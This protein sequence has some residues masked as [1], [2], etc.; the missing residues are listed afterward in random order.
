MEMRRYAAQIQSQNPSVEYAETL[1]LTIAKDIA[2]IADS[3]DRRVRTC[4]AQ[5]AKKLLDRLVSYRTAATVASTIVAGLPAWASVLAS[6]GVAALQAGSDTH[7]ERQ[8]IMDE[9]GLSF[10]ITMRDRMD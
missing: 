2:P 6:A 5:W 1:A 7:F 4:K 10:L 9:S 8:K 3:I